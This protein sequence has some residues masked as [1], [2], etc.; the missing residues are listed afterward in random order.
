MAV[1]PPALIIIFIIVI[2]VIAF[3]IAAGSY[4]VINGKWQGPPW[5]F[6]II[7]VVEMAA[8]MFGLLVFA[9]ASIIGGAAD[10]EDAANAPIPSK[11]PTI[12]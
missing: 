1:A 12:S 5:C 6:V 11:V 2:V 10:A 7:A 3:V 4:G 8:M 9:P